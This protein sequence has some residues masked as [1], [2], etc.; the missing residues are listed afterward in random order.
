MTLSR[1]PKYFILA[2]S[3][4]DIFYLKAD[5]C[6]LGMDQ[7][8]VNVLARELGE[9]LGFWKPIIVSHHMLM[10]LQQPSTGEMD[11]KERTIELKMS[12]SKPDTAIFMTDTEEEIIRKLGKAWCPEK[13]VKENPVMEYYRYIVFERFDKV[14]IK[15]PEKFGGNMTIDSYSMLE[16]E[17]SEGKIHPLDLKK[18]CATYINELVKPVREHFEKDPEAKRL[19]EQVDSFEVTR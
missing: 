4:A 17:Y 10:G 7:R 18:T 6:Q 16:K 11:A 2:C 13:E 3:A 9:K 8:K 5:I 12:K 15:R 19:K 1:H 14:E